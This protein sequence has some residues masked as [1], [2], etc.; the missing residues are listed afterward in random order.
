MD[1]D[2]QG[3]DPI[4]LQPNDAAVPFTFATPVCTSAT[5]NDGAIPYGD[6]ASSAAVSVSRVSSSFTR[7]ST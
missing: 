4:V 7:S 5:A 2:F 6:S 1:D 3:N